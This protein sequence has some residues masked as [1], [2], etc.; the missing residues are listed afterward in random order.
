MVIPKRMTAQIDH[1]CCLF[2]IGMGIN[3]NLPPF[4]LGQVGQLCEAAGHRKSLPGRVQINVIANERS[5]YRNG[6][7]PV[8]HHGVT[9]GEEKTSQQFRIAGR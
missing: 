2:L 5:I 9:D 7:L 6:P 4:G 8:I 3:H 1:T